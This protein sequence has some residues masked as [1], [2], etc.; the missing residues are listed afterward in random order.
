MEGETP[1]QQSEQAQP[2]ATPKDMPPKSADQ[3]SGKSYTEDDVN[4]IVK[5]RLSRE[6]AKHADYD[7]AKRKAEKADGLQSELDKANAQISELKQQ[8]EQ[9]E[10]ERELAGIRSTVAAKYGIADPT[11]LVAG[12]D[13]DQ[14][15]E[16]ARKLMKVFRPYER[17][18]AARSREAS[19]GSKLTPA[20]DFARAMKARGY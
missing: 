14:I 8:A 18:D 13:E 16:F 5:E 17:L 19:A 12:D 20:Q 9:A 3:A 7:D 11:V 2:A 1:E 15:D 4:R 10:H 6:R